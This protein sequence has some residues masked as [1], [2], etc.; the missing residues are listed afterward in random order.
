ML[1]LNPGDNRFIEFKNRIEMA[2]KHWKGFKYKTVIDCIKQALKFGL[3]YVLLKKSED[4][5]VLS[6]L[7]RQIQ[8]EINFHLANISLVPIKKEGHNFLIGHLQEESKVGDLVIN[9]VRDRYQGY[10]LLL[11]SPQCIYFLYKQ[12][13][14]E[15]PTT[16]FSYEINK[17]NFEKFW[18]I[19]YLANFSDTK[20]KRVNKKNFSEQ[21]LSW[22]QEA[23][24]LNL[25]NKI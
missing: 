22:F 19:F 5:T 11:K 16:N 9:K 21:C 8:Q 1:W 15:L 18:E 3:E 6:N 23:K 12:I 14:Y 17:D 25:A 4:A 10:H 7:V 24:I 13:L 20:E 2:L